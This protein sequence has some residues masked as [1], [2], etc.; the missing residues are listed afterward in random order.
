MESIEKRLGKSQ[1]SKPQNNKTSPH[2][3]ASLRPNFDEKPTSEVEI[4]I[5]FLGSKNNFPSQQLRWLCDMFNVLKRGGEM[6]PAMEI[7]TTD[8]YGITYKTR[9]SSSL[10]AI[11]KEGVLF[12]ASK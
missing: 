11:K 2:G 1:G 5:R 6:I 4:R 3:S 9:V 8:R 10:G 7:S 12:N